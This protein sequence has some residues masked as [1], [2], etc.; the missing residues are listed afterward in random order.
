MMKVILGELTEILLRTSTL[1]QMVVDFCLGGGS[2]FVG[3]GIRKAFERKGHEVINISRT[4]KPKSI[5]WV[6]Y[7]QHAQIID[8]LS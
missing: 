3:Q 2:G 1:L 5:T 8:N 4:P 6:K 7:C